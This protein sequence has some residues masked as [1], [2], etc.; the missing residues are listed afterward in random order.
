MKE[1]KR[2]PKVRGLSGV[3]CP[4]GAEK[5]VFHETEGTA[6][7]ASKMMTKKMNSK[8]STKELGYWKSYLSYWSYISYIRDHILY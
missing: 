3:Y 6:E 8:S 5:K 7:K 1:A 4:T 2:Q